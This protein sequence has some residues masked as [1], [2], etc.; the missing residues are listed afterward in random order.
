[1]LGKFQMME[2]QSWKGLT[3][4]NHIGAIYKAGPQKFSDMMVQLLA[5]YRGKTLETYLSQFP[6]KYFDTSD[7]YTWDIVGSSR[8]NI[9]LVEARDLDGNVISTGNAGVGGEAF[10]VIFAEDWFADGEVIVGEKNEI[11]PLRILGQPRMEGSNTVYKV[12]LMGGV[13]EG[14][15]A[16]ELTLG[17]RFS[18]DFAVVERELSRSVGGTRYTTPVAMR[19]E[20]STIRIA[21]KVPGGSLERKL[22]TGLPII[23][24]DGQKKILTTWMHYVDYQVEETFAEYK[25]NLIMYGRSNRNLNGEYLNIGKSGNVIRQGAGLR[26]QNEVANTMYY[27]VFD[28]K[29]IE[30]ALFELSSS[31]LDLNQRTFV[32]RTGERGA[33]L[34]HK[35]VLNVVSGWSTFNY[36]GGNAA[37]P[38]II[39]KTSS[40]LHSNALSAGF[41]F[42]EY[43]APNNVT[44]KVEIDPYLDDPVRNK[45]IHPLGGVASSYRFDIY[46]IG[47]MDQPNIQLCKIKGEEELRG[48]QWGIR[49]PFTGQRNNY[50]MSFDEDAAIIHKMATLGVAVLDPSRTMSIIPSILA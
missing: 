35:A 23:T 25:G 13:L 14:M 30:E 3:N 29:L 5:T 28:I 32:L 2:F 44:V 47:T 39:S 36:L 41:Q 27:N 49:N 17:K 19:N 31:K 15:P 22:K 48:Y 38:A 21:E 42:V 7:E 1:M 6:T 33:A 18:W 40:P 34:F 9:P 12:E 46:Y 11:Y 16:E 10:Y 24:G 4:E 45:I 37:N 20:W 8:R 43:K 26:E 50:N